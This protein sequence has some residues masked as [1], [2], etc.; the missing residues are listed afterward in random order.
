M[1][2][3][4]FSILSGISASVFAA[5]ALAGGFA[6]EQQNAA[7][8]GAAYAGA[9]AESGDSG[10]IFYN[11]AALAQINGADASVS[12]TGLFAD[13]RYRNAGGTLLGLAP[14]GGVAEDS[15]ALV[16]VVLPS[17]S[18][19]WRA[20]DRIAFGLAINAPF[21][22][23]SHYADDSAIR[24]HALETN[25]KALSIAPTIAVAV[26]DS[27]SIGGSLRIQQL[28]FDASN[29]IDAA[30]ILAANS[31]PG[32]IPGTDDA[33]V[34]AAAKDWAF[35][36]Q[37]GFQAEPLS[38]TH[39]G[40]SFSSKVDHDLD[41]AATFDIAGSVAG[42]TLNAGFGLFENGGF[43]GAFVTPASIFGGVSQE[44][45]DALTLKASIGVTFWSSFEQI[46]LDFENPAQPPELLTQNWNDAFTASV[47]GEYA[48]NEKTVFRA[49][50]MFDETPVND[51]FASPRIQDADRLWVNAGFGRDLTRNISVDFAAGYVFV[52]GRAINQSAS[53]PENLFRGSLTADYSTNVFA[54]S[55][56]LRFTTN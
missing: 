24:Y 39:L 46:E 38:G 34:R 28:D 16:D 42:Q 20:T 22:L 35:G 52:D 49:G 9:Q 13:S 21:G 18:A 2:S 6:L 56:R 50:V 55:L 7:A 11:P 45:G 31:I 25:V 26:N 37:I 44:F 5:P 29:A 36:Y 17:L 4:K 14:T 15:G 19:G 54:A 32:F 41:G 33:F 1:S 43:S 8:L 12:V 10:F 27:F 48:W 53:L 3:V 23:H 51:Q 30:G 47:G 40:V